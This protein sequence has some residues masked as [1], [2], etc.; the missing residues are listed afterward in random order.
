MLLRFIAENIFSF[1]EATEFNLFPSSKTHSHDSHKIA[2][3]HAVALRMTALYGANGA[4][5]SN[6]V[7]SI[8][9]LQSI[10]AKG[11]LES[12]S[13]PT[14]PRF[15][16]DEACNG[17]PSALAIEFSMTDSVFYYHI[18][19]DRSNIYIEELYQSGKT[20]DELIF[21]RELD[22][23]G[24]ISIELSQKYTDTK[25]STEYKDA[26]RRVQRKDMSMLNFMGQYYA[27]SFPLITVAYRWFKDELCIVRPDAIFGIMP[28]LM[29]TNSDFTR[30][31]NEKLP[32]F[33]TGIEGLVSQREEMALQ[34]AQSIYKDESD[35]AKKTPGHPVLAV[36]RVTGEPFNI[37]Y[38]E[39]KLLKK[40][41]LPQ[42][43]M[44][45]GQL[46]TTPFF[47]ESDGSRRI[48]DYMPVL[49]YLLVRPDSVFIIDEMERSVHPI[50]IKELMRTISESNQAKGQLIFSTH[51]S[52]LLDQD[53]FRPDEIWFAQKDIDNST[54]LYPLSDFNIHNT[55]N[56][57]NGYL[58]GRYGGIPF[59]SNIKDF[60]I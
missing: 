55:A 24:A 5:K 35:L 25:V 43:T 3:G 20:K 60:E 59:L 30:M 52:C 44:P 16:Y 48:I 19:F 37:V 58:Q 56:I 42:H 14:D 32:H 53:I 26:I 36:N 10:V 12:I 18:E 57:E 6:L 40:T 54:R 51:E 15:F 27:D 41:I 38:E 23:N 49:Y 9:L 2:C 45:N 39:G 4:G 34:E 1:K 8:G 22:D 46:Q 28:H 21:K 29:D 47:L 7:R 13:F 50:L 33:K 31:V 11:A 17:K